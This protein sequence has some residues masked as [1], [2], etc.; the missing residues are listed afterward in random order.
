MGWGE[1]ALGGMEIVNLPVNPHG[2]L[3]EPFVVHLAREMRRRIDV[4]VE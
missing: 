1:V 4:L 2:M 3:V